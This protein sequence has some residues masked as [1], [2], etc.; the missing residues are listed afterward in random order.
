MVKKI[1]YPDKQV[2][3]TVLLISMIAGRLV[4]GI[5]RLIL[6]GLTVSSFT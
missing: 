5:V 1:P 2:T 4:W 6:T 3:Y